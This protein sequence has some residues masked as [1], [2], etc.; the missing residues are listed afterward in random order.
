M[1]NENEGMVNT[2]QIPWDFRQSEVRDELHDEKIA[3]N[4]DELR[5]IGLR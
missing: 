5:E 1:L 4:L 3:E 2:P